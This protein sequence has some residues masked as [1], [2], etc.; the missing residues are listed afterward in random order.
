MGQSLEGRTMIVT[1]ASSG[2]GRAVARHFAGLGVKLALFARSEAK[3]RALAAELG[4]EA[5]FLPVDLAKP[6]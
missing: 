6:D 2:I 3:L 4:G 1:G 5:V